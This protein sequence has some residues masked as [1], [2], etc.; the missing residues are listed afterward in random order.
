MYLRL[1]KPTF[2]AIL[3]RLDKYVYKWNLLYGIEVSRLEEI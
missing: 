3:T 1:S 2:H